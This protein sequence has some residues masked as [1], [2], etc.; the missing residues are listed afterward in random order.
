MEERVGCGDA[1]EA[2]CGVVGEGGGDA[3]GE[4][5]GDEASGGVAGIRDLGGGGFGDV[6]DDIGME[7]NVVSGR[8]DGGGEAS[9]GVVNEFGVG[10]EVAATEVS[11]RM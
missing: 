7:S 9:G 4:L 3:V 2:A 8:E 11:K 10:V 1:R 5:A 6:D